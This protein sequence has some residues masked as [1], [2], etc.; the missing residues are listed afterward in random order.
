MYDPARH[1]P[2][3]PDP[4]D[5]VAARAALQEIIDDALS[6]FDPERFWP[7]HPLEDGLPD[8]ATGLYFG[9]TGVIWALDYLRRQGATV[10]ADDFAPVL[11]RLLAANRAEYASLAAYPAHASLL[12]GDVGV[13]M[14]ATRL[15]PAWATADEL[16]RRAASNLER[17]ALELMWGTADTMLA[18]VFMADMTG[19]DRWHQLYQAQARRLLAELEDTPFG[20]LWTQPLYG[21]VQRYLGTVHGYAGNMLALLRGWSWLDAGQRAQIGAAI[22]RALAA[23]ARRSDM[24]VTWHAIVTRARPPFLVQHCHGAPGIVTVFADGP[25]R[26]LEMDEL[27][28]QAGHFI[29]R[30]GPLAKG[31][32]LCHGTG[33]NGYA[34]LKLYARFGDILWLERARAFARRR[35]HNIATRAG[36]MGR[37]DIRCGPAI[38]ASR[39]ICGIASRRR[40]AFQR[41][42]LSDIPAPPAGKVA[43]ASFHPRSLRHTVADRRNRG[44][45]ADHP[46][47]GGSRRAHQSWTTALRCGPRA[48]AR[49]DHPTR[50]SQRSIRPWLCLSRPDVPRRPRRQV[51]IPLSNFRRSAITSSSGCRS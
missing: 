12:M 15:A 48:Q 46:W 9:A 8:G 16:F 18:C 3:R 23:S 19:E 27:L 33:G 30:A 28:R 32:D 20:P 7:S 1:V 51:L 21:E 5:A 36:A 2:L 6:H 10:H 49:H 50:R 25:I 26:T 24:G 37:A 4:W 44:A 42:T 13:L 34:F 45:A 47:R 35:S 29:W 22:P 38:S 31:P 39:S 17:P 40:R 41:R 43:G 11:P 14:L